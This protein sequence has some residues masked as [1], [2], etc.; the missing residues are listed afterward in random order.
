MSTVSNS[1]LEHGP[2]G[3]IALNSCAE[4]GKMVN[5]HLATLRK[6]DPEKNNYLIEVDMPRFA[7]GEGKVKIKESV[8][9]KDIYILADIGNHGCTYK[10]FGQDHPMSPDDHMMDIKRTLS[11]IGGKA[12]RVTVVMPLL[13]ASRQHRRKGRESLDCAMALQELEH[14]GVSTIITFD[15]H[16]P[17]IQNA[18]P[19]SSFE[20]VFP[21]YNILKALIKREGQ[22]FNKD[23]LVV[24]SPD[25]GAMDRAIYY[26]NVLDLDV[27]LFY[28]RRDHTRVEDG[29]NPIVQHEYIGRSL[30][31][32]N[33][34]IVDDMIASGESVLDIIDQIQKFNVGKVYVAST[35]GFFTEGVEKFRKYYDD[36]K[37]NTVYCTNASYLYPALLNEPWFE[38]VD[39]SKFVAK[40]MHT[41]NHDLSISPLLNASARIRKLI[42]TENL[43]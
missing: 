25:T 35:F 4:L 40:L 9:G 28:K 2:V 11:A 29:K 3:I 21:T 15:A 10:M 22:V 18:I 6:E 20:N 33:V 34:L 41:L 14:L 39:I 24:I 38:D 42:A 19:N 27:G 30:E 5:N 13:Y 32:M 17:N 36:G 23:N 43:K 12:N 37:L 16:D 7:N 1:T 8:R 26:A 31:G